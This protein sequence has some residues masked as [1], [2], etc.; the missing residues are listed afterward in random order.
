[1][2]TH[3]RAWMK[4][5]KCLRCKHRFPATHQNIYLDAVGAKEVV[6]VTCPHCGGDVRVDGVPSKLVDKIRDEP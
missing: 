6:L 1:M 5:V 4:E 2:A 3:V